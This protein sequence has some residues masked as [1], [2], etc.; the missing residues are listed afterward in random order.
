MALFDDVVV[1]AK[2]AAA[3]VSK[4]AGAFYDLS[5]L[6]ISCAGLRGELTKK[7]QAL[8]EAVY[9]NDPEAVITELK[10][11]ITD[12]KHDIADIERTIAAASNS[13]ICAQCGEKLP[14]SA[15]FCYTCG[16]RVVREESV[17]AVLALEEPVK[18]EEKTEETAE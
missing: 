16:A 2:S 4:K 13:V 6:R 11:E 7:Y 5:K 15:R 3:A 8:G 9:N 12:L 10:E 14:K 1:N 17:A 18:A